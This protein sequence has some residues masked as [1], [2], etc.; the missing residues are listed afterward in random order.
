MAEQ[1]QCRMGA[2]GHA[3]SWTTPLT[4]VVQALGTNHFSQKSQVGA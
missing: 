3:V 2:G 4:L 1:G